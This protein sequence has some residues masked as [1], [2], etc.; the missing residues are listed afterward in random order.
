MASANQDKKSIISSKKYLFLFLREN[1]LGEESIR[2]KVSMEGC[3][4]DKKTIDGGVVAG[5][6]GI[7]I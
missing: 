3:T 6:L 1:H 2:L 7:I 5:I 4:K